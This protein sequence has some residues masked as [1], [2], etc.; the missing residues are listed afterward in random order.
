VHDQGLR[1]TVQSSSA[2][3]PIKA[4]GREESFRRP[5]NS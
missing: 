5:R 4:A 1:I 2:L 3:A